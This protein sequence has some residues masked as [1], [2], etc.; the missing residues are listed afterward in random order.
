[1]DLLAELNGLDEEDVISAIRRETLPLVM[2]GAGSSAPEVSF[3]LESNGIHISDIFVDDDFYTESLMFQGRRVLSYSMLK[4]KYNRVNVILG[5]SNYEKKGALE[6]REIVNRAFC[7]FSIS[8]NI[9]EKTPIAEIEQHIQEFESVYEMLEDR[10]S[11]RNLLAYLKTRVSG[12]NRHIVNV[13]EKETNF[14]HNDIFCIGNNE[15]YLDV[16]AFDGDTIRLFLNENNG[17]YR[18]IYAVEADEQNFE[19]LQQFVKDSRINN[20]ELSKLG[21]WNKKEKL[22]FF[23]SCEQVSGILLEENLVDRQERISIEAVPLDEMFDYSDKVTLL[24]INYF[25]GVKETV[26]G[27]ENIL[28][29][30]MPNLAVTVGFDCRNIRS[31]PGILKRINPNYKLYLRFNRGMTSGLVLYGVS[32]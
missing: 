7:L 14:F 6:E 20:V 1:M 19:R 24:K 29:K 13:F 15:V 10:K 30:H 4:Q 2:W 27:A 28:R 3:Y 26:E 18:K 31:I 23:S 17:C 11:K 8:Y 25:E 22:H 32:I 9:F 21:A 5:N 16:G 12:D